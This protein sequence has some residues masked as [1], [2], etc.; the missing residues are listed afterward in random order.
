MLPLKYND[1]T[2]VRRKLRLNAVMLAIC[3]V[4]EIAAIILF[5]L[6]IVD[7]IPMAVVL[8]SSVTF[9]V[10]IVNCRRILRGERPWGEY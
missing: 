4:C 10:N 6:G 9:V 7:W 5:A 3:C 2:L 1:E 8:A